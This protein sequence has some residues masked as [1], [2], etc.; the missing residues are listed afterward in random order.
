MF[1]YSQRVNIVAANALLLKHQGISSLNADSLLYGVNQYPM[2][3]YIDKTYLVHMAFIHW[4]CFFHPPHGV[5]PCAESV[6]FSNGE[7]STENHCVPLIKF[8]IQKRMSRK[9]KT[10]I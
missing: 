3:W 4:Y 10:N 7:K 5:V 8:K 2:L 1:I 9:L 6:A